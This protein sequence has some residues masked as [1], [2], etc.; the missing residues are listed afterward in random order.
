MGFYRGPNIVRDG[1]VAYYDVASTRC[2]DASTTIT[3]NT[4]LNNLAGGTM[5]MIPYDITNSNMSFVIDNGNYVYNQNGINGGYPGWYSSITQSR[6]DNYTFICWFKYTYGASNQRS[7]NIYGGG[8]NSRT[9][10]YLSPSGTS[11]SHGVLRYSNGGS[12]DYYSLTGAYGGNDNTWHQF[13]AVDTGPDGAHTTEVFI[14][15]VSKGSVTSNTNYDTPHGSGQ[16]VWGSWSNTYGNFNGKSNCFM[17]YN[18]AL[19]SSEIVH[20]YNVTKSRFQ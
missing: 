18:R 10:W 14:D 16:M 11:I 9:S 20:N 4:R 19:D 1:L 5:Q 17:Y 3:T 6:T 8:F 12:A 15:G 13:A 2:V 7:N